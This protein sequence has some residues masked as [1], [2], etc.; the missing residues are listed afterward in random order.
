[1]YSPADI[2]VQH[3]DLLNTGNMLCIRWFQAVSITDGGKN[4][5][6]RIQA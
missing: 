1:M 6:V 2:V 3:G 5:W 4:T